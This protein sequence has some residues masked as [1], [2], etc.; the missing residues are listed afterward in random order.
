MRIM[1]VTDAW[2]PQVNGVVRTMKRVIEETEAMGHVWEIVHPGQG[3]RTMPLPTYPEIKLALFARHRIEERFHEF[4]P[5]AIHIA[6]EGTLGMAGR[7]M[8]LT[9]KHP[10]STA[11]HTRFPEYVAA[12]LP[13]PV[14]AGYSFV[15]WFHKYSGKVMVPTPS[16]VEELKAQRFINLVA[17]SRGVDTTMFNPDKRIPEGAEDDPFK[18]LAR[19]IFLNVGRVAV[20][21]N[22]EAFAELDLPGTKVIIGDGPQREELE[23]RYEDVVFLGAKFGEELATYY[24][25]ADVF[26]FPSLTDTFGLVVLEAMASGT[27]VAAYEATGPRDVIPGSNA[28]TITPIGGDLAAGAKACLDLD[29]ETCRKYAEGY[30]WR[31]CAEAFIEN[32]QPL[33]APARKRFWQKIRLRRRKKPQIPGL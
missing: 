29:R 10:F 13:I 27:P 20:E 28:G 9:V 5:D 11:Y 14:S 4:E 7:A 22:I 1:L 17:W 32:L 15:R 16:M 2:D 21:K 24:A 18:G 12:R 19:P 25:C 31:A 30:S 8:C 33:P 3:F 6:T 23:K 26:V